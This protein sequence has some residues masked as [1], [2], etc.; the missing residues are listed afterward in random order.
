MIMNDD[1]ETL[2]MEFVD[3]IAV[4]FLDIHLAL[5]LVEKEN[6]GFLMVVLSF[7]YVKGKHSPL[8]F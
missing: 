5:E 8:R 6:A 2:I 1:N 4:S 3:F 7:E